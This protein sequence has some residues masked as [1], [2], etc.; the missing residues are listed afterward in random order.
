MVIAKQMTMFAFDD[1]PVSK[2]PI[3][4]EDYDGKHKTVYRMDAEAIVEDLNK[5]PSGK[6]SWLRCLEVDHSRLYE[7]QFKDWDACIWLQ[8]GIGIKKM[9]RCNGDVMDCIDPH[10]YRWHYLHGKQIRPWKYEPLK[11]AWI[12]GRTLHIRLNSGEFMADILPNSMIKKYD[13]HP[14][15]PSYDLEHFAI[16]CYRNKLPKEMMAWRN[17]YV[18]GTPVLRPFSRNISHEDAK[19]ISLKGEIPNGLVPNEQFNQICECAERI[20]I[21]L[22]LKYDVPPL[23]NLALY[24]MEETCKTC[25]RR[26]TKNKSKDSE[27]WKNNGQMCC[28]S[29]MWDRKTPARKIVKKKVEDEE[30]DGW[31]DE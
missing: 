22:E 18:Y 3:W 24:P 13:L 9:V 10:P 7:E 27:C 29:Y 30:A 12:D 21:A 5:M 2:E 14:Y 11:E 6:G 4:L 26:K 17:E 19:K 23:M 15:R 16:E 1:E 20:G 25:L 8:R 31:D 28:S